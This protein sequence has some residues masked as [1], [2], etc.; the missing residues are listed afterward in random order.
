MLDTLNIYSPLNF[1]NRRERAENIKKI[2]EE[3]TKKEETPKE[4]SLTKNKTYERIMNESKD[5]KN[6]SHRN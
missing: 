5:L 2:I 4:D 6:E 3:G 1:V